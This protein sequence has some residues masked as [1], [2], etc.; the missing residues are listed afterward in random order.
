MRMTRVLLLFL[1]LC[2]LLCG[3]ALFNPDKL[4]IASVSPDAGLVDGQRYTFT[5][6]VRYQLVSVEQGELSVGFNNGSE[7]DVYAMVSS[8]DYI[9]S[10]GTGQ[11]TFSASATAKKWVGSPFQ[12]IVTLSEYPH[13]GSTWTNLASDKRNLQF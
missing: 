11:H 5:V 2:L 8:G 9:I 7:S 10:K 6:E 1:S 4:S 13:S 12:A 3:C